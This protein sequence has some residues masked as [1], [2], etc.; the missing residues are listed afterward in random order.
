MLGIPQ[1]SEGQNGSGVSPECGKAADYGYFRA[2]EALAV[3]PNVSNLWGWCVPGVG[4]GVR[5]GRRMLA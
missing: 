4:R 3:G 5:D 2:G 1:A